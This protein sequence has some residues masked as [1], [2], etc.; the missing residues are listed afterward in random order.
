MDPSAL[1]PTPDTLPVSWGWFELLLIITL[2]L[3]IILMNVMLGTGIIALVNHF[4]G[5]P[6]SEP[7]TR[8]IAG[9]LPFAIAF[10]VNFGVAPLLFV[11]VLY[12]H[13][14]YTSSVLMANFWLFV[15]AFLVSGY[16][17]AYIYDYKY[18]ALQGARVPVLGYTVF[19]LVAIAFFMTNNFTLAQVPETWTRYFD[20]PTGF[21]LN[22]GDP[23][24][25]PR[26]LHMI[27]A[28]IAVGGMS[29]ALYYELK[30]RRGDEEAARWVRHGCSW[31]G[32]ATI[33]NF[34]FGFWFY[35]MLPEQVR[36]SST[37]AGGMIGVLLLAG[38]IL[39]A[40][41]I[42]YSLRGKILPAMYTVLPTILIMILIRD[43]V[44]AAYL[45]P[46]FSLSDL[47]VVS[48][49]SPMVVFLIIFLGGLLLNYWMFKLAWQVIGN[50]E[51]RS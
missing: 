22:L 51:V 23:I 40:L 29:I 26:L 42:I 30:R 2:F 18:D 5:G 48:Q 21:L 8:E 27:T 38:V 43:L 12:G 17:M 9:K 7:L 36:N 32:Y 35:G 39:A 44:R 33:A 25:F 11:Q 31:F 15:I 20:S 41:S 28:A 45:R 6:D 47:E 3:H 24:L 14:F 16:Y 4:R 1:I 34:G 49:H 10:T 46:Y 50:R 19:A 37:L 13:F